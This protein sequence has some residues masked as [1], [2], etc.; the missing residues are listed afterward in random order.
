MKRAGDWQA[1]HFGCGVLG[2]HTMHDIQVNSERFFEPVRPLHGTGDRSSKS[3]SRCSQYFMTGTSHTA[4]RT[5]RSPSDLFD[6]EPNRPAGTATFE[7]RSLSL[8]L[9]RRPDR[10]STT[11]VE[12]LSAALAAHPPS[13]TPSLYFYDRGRCS[14]TSTSP[15]QCCPVYVKAL[16]STTTLTCA[17]SSASAPAGS[18]HEDRLVRVS[19]VRSTTRRAHTSPPAPRCPLAAHANAEVVCAPPGDTRGHVDWAVAVKSS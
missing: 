17:A 4:P 19:T 15:P 10:D 8:S 11:N 18:Q 14:V 12:I 1:L 5:H 7:A 6:T 16:M 13:C 9:R 3:V 2:S